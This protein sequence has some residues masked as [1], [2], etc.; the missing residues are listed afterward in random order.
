MEVGAD[1]PSTSWQW[2][3]G[4]QG[5]AGGRKERD[6]SRETSGLPGMIP[7][8][9]RAGKRPAKGLLPPECL[10]PGTRRAL[11]RRGGPAPSPGG[12]RPGL[13]RDLRKAQGTETVVSPGCKHL[14]HRGQGLSASGE[15]AEKAPSRG[16]HLGTPAG[17]VSRG[18]PS[19]AAGP[20]RLRWP[21][22]GRGLG[23]SLHPSWRAEGSN[24]P[25]Q[26]PPVQ[27]LAH[28]WELSLHEAPCTW[29]AGDKGGPRPSTV[30]MLTAPGWPAGQGQRPRAV[31][32]ALLMLALE[33]MDE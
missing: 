19:T 12:P 25:L 33:P 11:R 2:V 8:G 16:A 28:L 5:A 27:P 17:Q 18:L 26:A 13:G 21:P 9:V 15:K 14:G 24:A 6:R 20:G 30:L 4:H 29:T 31:L 10:L 7:R 1:R 22:S 3:L 32:L 23:S